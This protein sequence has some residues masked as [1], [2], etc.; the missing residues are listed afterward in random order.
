MSARAE[1]LIL[2]FKQTIRK[3][4]LLI[5][6]DV[7]RYS[8]MSSSEAQLDCILKMS[9][10][11]LI[12]DVGANEGQFVENIRAGGFRGEVVSFEPLTHAYKMLLERSQNDPKWHIHPQCAIGNQ[13]GEININVSA[14]SVSSS[15]LP[16]LENHLTS[17]PQSAYLRQEKVQ[18]SKL[19][20]VSSPYMNRAIAPF[21]KI[22]TQGYESYVLDGAQETLQ[23]CK[24]VLLEL[25]L[26]PLYEGQPQWRQMVDRLE[27]LGFSLW[28]L[29]PEFTDHKTGRTLQVNGIFLR[30]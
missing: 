12:L 17:A 23:R 10:V 29:V 22:D 28:A 24:G 30:H 9:G 7:H 19:D 20:D 2:N 14:N 15:I 6:L 4:L 26:I 16:M 21:L 11:D 5:G 18:I 8:A 13:Q 27:A 25:S 3:A 1:R